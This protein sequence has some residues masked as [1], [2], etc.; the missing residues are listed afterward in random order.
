MTVPVDPSVEEARAWVRAELSKAEYADD[1]SLLQRVI[2]W[3]GE[4]LAR[5]FAGE[6]AA[7]PGWVLPIVL[8][9]VAAL[10]ALVL[11]FRVRRD[12]RSTD[13]TRGRGLLDE[14]HLGADDYRA[15]ARRARDAGDLDA[16]VADFFRAIAAGAAERAIIDDSPGRTA[17]EVSL[18]LAQVFPDE[19]TALADAADRFDAIRYGDVH[20]EAATVRAV[21][22]LD[23]RL[24]TAR[25]F[26][27]RTPVGT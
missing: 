17:H 25:P 12:P 19:A 20:A 8:T 10:V 6:G 16:A 2:D 24:R 18:A 7:L 4:L 21:A 26:L 9:T 5:L 15:R 13:A 3:I 1:R 11:L 27:S 23:E 14:P 22:D